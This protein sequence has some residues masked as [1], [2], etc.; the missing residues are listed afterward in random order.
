MWLEVALLIESRYEVMCSRSLN[1]HLS[2]TSCFSPS[3]F[4]A[5]AVHDYNINPPSE[6]SQVSRALYSQSLLV[7]A[8]FPPLLLVHCP[9]LVHTFP[10]H[11]MAF[12][13]FL[14]NGEEVKINGKSKLLS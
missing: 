7:V 1:L 2:N 10:V 8:D 14:K 3:T 6:L 9:I 11:E 13:V 12:R 4:E 5:Y